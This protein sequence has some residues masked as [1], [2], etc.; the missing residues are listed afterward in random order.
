MTPN[1]AELITLNHFSEDI[2]LIE[3]QAPVGFQFEAG[4]YVFLGLAAD[5]MKPFSIASAPSEL[6]RLMFQIRNTHH[7]P[8]MEAFFSALNQGAQLFISEAHNHL[9][10]PMPSDAESLILIAGGTGF[11]PL[12]SLLIQALANEKSPK[13]YLFW[14]VRDLNE[15][16]ARQELESLKHLFPELTYC[17]SLSEPT[18]GCDWT[19]CVGLIHLQIEPV[20]GHD[21]QKAVAILCGPPPMVQSA[22]TSLIQKGMKESRI[23]A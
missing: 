16:Y 20:I 3:L 23:F 14:G 7:S 12:R 5:D 2:K 8:W 21:L 15:F 6:P 19:G 9:N 18:T 13:I 4:Q 17:V 10:H 1:T 22:K 11:A